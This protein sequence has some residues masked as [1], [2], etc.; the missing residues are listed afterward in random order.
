MTANATQLEQVTA[1]LPAERVRELRA[2]AAAEDRS[3]SS[4]IRRAVEAY[5]D[6]QASEAAA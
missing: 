4:V 1:L 3:F 6:A 2:I 5:I